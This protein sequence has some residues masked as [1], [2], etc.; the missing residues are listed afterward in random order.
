MAQRHRLADIAELQE[1]I[2]W[3]RENGVQ[4]IEYEG[5][6]LTLD[7]EWR[8]PADAALPVA[9][10]KR[11]VDPAAMRRARD[12]IMYGPK[13]VASQASRIPPAVAEEGDEP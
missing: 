10:T 12:R 11:S 13:G 7:P 8:P 2:A 9:P 4:A 6:A 3:M 5:V 1:T